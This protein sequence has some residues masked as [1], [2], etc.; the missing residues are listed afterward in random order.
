VID[1]PPL[2]D[3]LR[4]IQLAIAPVFLLAGIGAILNVIAGRLN[5][6]V[7]RSRLV[8]RWHGETEG[9][10]H[11]RH[12]EELRLIDRRITLAS[13]AIFLS[14][15]SAVTVCLLV[16][17]LFVGELL[18]VNLAYLVAALFVL[19]MGLLGMGLILFLVE[20]RV[21]VT[22]IKVREELLERER[23]GWRRVR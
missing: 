12:V 14:V 6:V 7:D 18:R 20:T 3:V 22:A 10:E 21:A 5:R 1:P 2:S 8:E 23:R 15:A 9:A 4:I 19:A 16:I 11:V 13:N 17:L